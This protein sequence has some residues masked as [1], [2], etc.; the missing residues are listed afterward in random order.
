MERALAPPDKDQGVGM[1]AVHEPSEFWKRTLANEARLLAAVRGLVRSARYAPLRLEIRL[2][3]PR[4]MPL[5]AGEEEMV[6]WQKEKEKEKEKE[7][8]QQKQSAVDDDFAI[9][10]D[11]DLFHHAAV[12]IGLHGAGLS[13]IL[14][15]PPG[16]HVLEFSLAQSHSHYYAHLAAALDQPYWQLPVH[17]AL[18]RAGIEAREIELDEQDVTTVVTEILDALLK[19]RTE[20][21]QHIHAEL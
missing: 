10:R 6:A 12:I 13:N 16:C 2:F 14:F 20:K 17:P 19:E 5:E 4:S 18:Y 7:K 11:I 15:A 9:G 21:G 8:Q 3:S 1:Y